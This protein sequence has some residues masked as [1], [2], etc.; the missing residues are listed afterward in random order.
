MSPQL[1]DALVEAIHHFARKAGLNI[2]KPLIRVAVRALLAEVERVDVATVRRMLKQLALPIVARPIVVRAM[3]QVGTP[4][5]RK[6]R[7]P[8]KKTKMKAKKF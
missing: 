3:E 7:R 2:P 4:S 6:R 1:E 8:A 5:A